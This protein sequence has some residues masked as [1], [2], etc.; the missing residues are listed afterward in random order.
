[1]NDVKDLAQQFLTEND[2]NN[3][4]Y[5]AL[6]K[7]AENLGFV[8]VEFSNILNDSDVQNVI[9][10][11]KLNKVV[12]ESRAFTYADDKFRII[13]INEDLGEKEKITVLTHELGHIICNHF[14]SKAIIGN[15]VKE[16]YEANEF[17]HY[18]LNRG[19]FQKVKS[20]IKAHK[21]LAVSVIAVIMVLAIGGI[22]CGYVC[23]QQSYYGEYYIT[24]SGDR[25]HKK[26]CIFVKNKTDAERLTKED[27]ESGKYKPCN[28]CLPDK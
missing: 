6:E 16:E 21:K 23:K 4:D 12:S 15:D 27:F 1:M 22:V 9:D 19:F 8:V 25:Y 2:L 18:V 17:V 10:N 26:D 11:L 20:K 5:K 13:F 7:A 3:P 24:T 28:T 14:G